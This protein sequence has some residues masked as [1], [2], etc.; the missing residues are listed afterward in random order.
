MA[1]GSSQ[2]D[3]RDRYIVVLNDV[4]VRDRAA[5]EAVGRTFAR[6]LGHVYDVALKGFAATIDSSSVEA[7]RRDPRVKYIQQ[8]GSGYDNATDTNAGWGVGRIDQRFGPSDN[9][10]TSNF[11]GQ[12]V[13]I[14]IVDGGVNISHPDFGGR[15]TAAATWNA[16]YPAGQDSTGHGTQAASVAAG[17]EYGVAKGANIRSVRVNGGGGAGSVSDWIWG[18][19]WVAA[20]KQNPAILSFSKS[21]GDF[22]QGTWYSGAL[23]DAI[24]GTKN[25]GIFVVVAAGN[26]NA[27]ACG[28]SP[29]QVLEVMVV[30]ATDETDTRALF[31]DPNFPGSNYGS[32]I[33]IFA[34]GKNLNVAYATG[35]YG[36]ANG[37]S[38][39]AP[40]VAGAAALLYQQYPTDS[41]DQIHYAII[42]GAS[43]VVQVQG[44]GPNLLL[45]SL[46]PAPVQVSITGPTYA[47]PFSDCSWNAT[48]TAGRG[49]FTYTWS[50]LLA[51]SGAGISGRISQSG[52][53]MV[54]V[55]DALGGYSTATHGVEFDPNYGGFTCQ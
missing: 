10:F 15:A 44:S 38:L 3:Y 52:G 18:I 14:Y 21:M 53:L 36:L 50:G 7:L 9:Q 24:R 28:F 43:P 6:R 19:N 35:G 1:G 5:V 25:A 12:N 8:D 33:D 13:N 29:S 40:M 20:N 2:E 17:S 39:S 32:C 34:P 4:L 49:P 22:W 16:A 46:L 31:T 11:T 26:K 23:D 27:N 51:G 42:H 45:Y 54:E 47:G 41:P 48:A 37:T 55:W 30:G